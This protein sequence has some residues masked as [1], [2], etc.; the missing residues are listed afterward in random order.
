MV[1]SFI[2]V[3]VFLSLYTIRNIIKII[4]EYSVSLVHRTSIPNNINDSNCS[5]NIVCHVSSACADKQET[6]KKSEGWNLTCLM[7]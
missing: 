7:S 2:F 4:N 3:S 5:S 1:E 6:N